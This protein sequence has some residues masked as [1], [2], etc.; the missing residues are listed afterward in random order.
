LKNQENRIKRITS[1]DDIPLDKSSDQFQHLV[2]Q[3]KVLTI[4]YDD[5]LNDKDDNVKKIKEAF[6]EFIL[7]FKCAVFC[8]TTPNQKAYMVKQVRKAGFITL[9]I[10]D[11]ANDVNMIQKAHVGIGI[12]GNEGK[13]AANCSDFAVAYFR[14]IKR[15]FILFSSNF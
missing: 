7:K 3:G 11:G 12:I 4:L 8:R 2:V 5:P 6:E 1:L 14:D 15:Y 9:A 10:G 13:Q